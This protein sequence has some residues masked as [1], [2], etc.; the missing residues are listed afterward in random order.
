VTNTELT[1]LI[2]AAAGVLSLV[3]WIGLIVVPA[4]GAYSR[5]W[6]RLAALVA[7]VYV[8]V[9]LATAGAGVGALILYYY[10]EL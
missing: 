8:L 4:W 9:A 6:E 2:A 10:D 3:A 5:I 1:Y 7:S